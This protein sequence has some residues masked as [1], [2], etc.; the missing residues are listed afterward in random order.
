MLISIF[1][2]PQVARTQDLAK[3]IRRAVA[4]GCSVAESTVSVN[5]PPVHIRSG[6]AAGPIRILASGTD[7]SGREQRITKYAGDTC[8]A[9]CAKHHVPWHGYE[10]PQL[11]GQTR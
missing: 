7:A 2:L 5:F 10:N 6:G 11:A 8:A 1:G 9:Y 3:Q 4:K